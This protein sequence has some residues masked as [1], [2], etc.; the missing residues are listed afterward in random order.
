MNFAPCKV[1]SARC[2]FDGYGSPGKLIEAVRT[3]ASWE[4]IR[5]IPSCTT[6]PSRET[7]EPARNAV[8][9]SAHKWFLLAR[10]WFEGFPLGD[11]EPRHRC[12]HTRRARGTRGQGP[13]MPRASYIRSRCKAVAL[14]AALLFANLPGIGHTMPTHHATAV[15][16]SVAVHA[17]LSQ[18]AR[19]HTL[20]CCIGSSC[21]DLVPLPAA[22]GLAAEPTG[23]RVR[24]SPPAGH[25]PRGFDPVPVLPPPR[26]GD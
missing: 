6:G 15:T 7:T 14:L 22:A 23:R 2:K 25:C 8:A 20:P 4:A 17:P 21:V 1:R 13:I 5:T 26:G 9:S 3:E 10:C 19:S 11:V 16:A 18:V 12:V 24:C